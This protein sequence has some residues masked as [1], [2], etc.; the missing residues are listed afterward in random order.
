MISNPPPPF[1]SA[2]WTRNNTTIRT[3]ILKLLQLKIL[4]YSDS[5]FDRNLLDLKRL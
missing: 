4:N 1:P 5:Y 2:A 3:F